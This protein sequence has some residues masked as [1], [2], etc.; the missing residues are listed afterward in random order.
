MTENGASYTLI[1]DLP[2][3]DRPRERLRDF[4]ADALSEAE[5]IAILL[6]TGGSKESALA[7]AQRLLR[8]F[9]GLAGL[10][11]A[12]FAELCNEKGIGEAKA[13]QIAAALELGVRLTRHDEERARR[14]SAPRRR[15]YAL[16][17]RR[18]VAASRR[19]TS[20]S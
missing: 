16:V 15:S 1:R 2:A 5:L 19:S 9:D 7:Q 12:P 11:H 8:D 3:T 10:R 17:L 14:C 13:A 18:D 4:G 20:A 6:R